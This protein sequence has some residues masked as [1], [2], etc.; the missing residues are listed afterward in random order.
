MLLRQAAN[1]PD[2]VAIRDRLDVVTYAR[3]VAEARRIARNLAVSG[4]PPGGIVAVAAK[5]TPEL[6]PLLLGILLAGCAYSVLDA[7]CSETRL[8]ASVSALRP[9][10]VTGDAAGGRALAAASIDHVPV[11]RL[12]KPSDG[13]ALPDLQPTD[14]ATVFWTSDSTAVLSPHRATTRL[15]AA[16]GCVPLG[17]AA[18]TLCAAATSGTVFALELWATLLSGGTVLP[19]RKD[20]LA[21]ADISGGVRRGATHLF[22]DSAQFAAVADDASCLSGLRVLTVGGDRLDPA[23]CRAV[24]AACPSLA[25]YNA[26]G[27]VENCGVATIHRVS[28]ADLDADGGIPLGRAVAGTSVAVWDGAKAVAAGERG[29]IALTG[30]G[31]A[32]GSLHAPE[33]TAAFPELDI[34]GVPQRAYLTGDR[35]WLDES[36]VLR[37]AE[38]AAAARRVTTVRSGQSRFPASACE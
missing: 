20:H 18:V 23:S 4:A 31:L 5:R 19:Y 36:G 2:A 30:D 38:P 32:L 12:R 14:P 33:R 28:Q 25:L 3:L 9:A 37:L 7:H 34:D 21:P 1:R 29:E 26:Y 35:G 22:L 17:P 10:V 16:G 24:L 11:E 6:P 8:A 27:A 13:P 15:V